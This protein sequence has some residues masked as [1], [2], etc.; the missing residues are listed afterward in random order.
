M[1]KFQGSF[2]TDR[3]GR[4]V[5]R[6]SWRNYAP[7][8]TTNEGVKYEYYL[9]LHVPNNT[10]GEKGGISAGYKL[11]WPSGKWITPRNF[12]TAVDAADNLADNYEK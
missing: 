3:E 2:V 7:A 11:V 5:Q 9:V 1:E 12:D 6:E 4:W 8:F 10:M